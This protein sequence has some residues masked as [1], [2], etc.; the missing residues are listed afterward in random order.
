MSDLVFWKT[1]IA[2]ILRQYR[3]FN[4]K[5]CHK[6][7]VN[8]KDMEIEYQGA[9]TTIGELTLEQAQ[10]LIF[11]LL[12]EREEVHE[13]IQKMYFHGKMDSIIEEDRL[14]K[15]EESTKTTPK[16]CSCYDC[17]HIGHKNCGCC[18]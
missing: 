9:K 15:P 6:K 16:Q 18:Q 1:T 14:E 12:N 11:E 4:F 8:K 17:A 7:Y 5:H 13:I 2:G 3:K 10:D